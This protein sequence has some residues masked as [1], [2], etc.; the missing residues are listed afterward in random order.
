MYFYLPLEKGLV[1]HFNK[2]QSLTSKNAL[3]Q[4]QLKLVQW[5]WRRFLNFVNGFSLFCHHLPL[6]KG[7]TLHSIK[8]ESP[9]PK[10][11][12]CQIRLKLAQWFWRRRLKCEKFTRQTDRLRTTNDQKS[13]LELSAQ[14]SMNKSLC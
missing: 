6:E 5:F 14:C 10:D 8:F 1:L 9:L 4:V 12:L 13:S 7:L 2:L 11:A 3:R